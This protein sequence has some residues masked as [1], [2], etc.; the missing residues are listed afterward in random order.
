MNRDLIWDKNRA[1]CIDREFRMTLMGLLGSSHVMVGGS[2][3]L[4]DASGEPALL[5]Q[6]S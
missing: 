3:D 5:V 2:G 1:K 4:A 6:A